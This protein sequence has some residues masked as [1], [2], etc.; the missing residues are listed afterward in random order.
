MKQSTN[1]RAYLL[2]LWRERPK[3]PWRASLEEAQSREKR[4]FANVESLM[5]FI[6]TQ[7]TYVPTASAEGGDSQ[8]SQ[9]LIP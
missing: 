6:E 3:G 4:N 9:T 2:R 5:A 7:T 1:Y 8:D